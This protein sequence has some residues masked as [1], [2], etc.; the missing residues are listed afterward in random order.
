MPVTA[1]GAGVAVVSGP[2]VGVAA[3]PGVAV[4]RLT[5]V[6]V[7]TPRIG[8]RVVSAC[9][10]QL[11]ADRTTMAATMKIPRRIHVCDARAS[12]LV[13]GS[14]IAHLRIDC[15]D[16]ERGAFEESLW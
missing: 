11:A 15:P 16:T 9:P 1:A 8:V 14:R 7:A 12:A 2:V 10:P 3:A 4:A 13:P 5:V 6:L